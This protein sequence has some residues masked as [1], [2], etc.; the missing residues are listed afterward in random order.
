VTTTATHVPTLEELGHLAHARELAMNGRGRV[1]PNPL[2]GAIVVNGGRV[3]G[4]GWHEGPGTPHAEVGALRDAGGGA[5]DAT[6]VCTLEPCSHHGRTPPCTDAII[7]SGVARV[8]IGCLDP[9]ERGR[10]GGATVLAEAGVD[11][12]LAPEADAEACREQNAAFVTHALTGRPLVT[13]KLATS[14]D[15]KVATATGETRWI[16][17]PESRGLV[18]RWRADMDAVA[19][20]IGTALADDPLLNVRD[21]DG[22]YRPPAR[23]VFD[24]HARLPLR[25]RLVAGA[26]EGP[27]IVVA[28]ADAP[29]DRVGRL[30]DA[31]VDVLQPALPGGADPVG[32]ALETLGGRGIQSLLLEGGPIL[33][34]AFLAR[35]AVDRV[36]WFVAPLLIGGARAPGALGGRGLGPLAE[37]PRLRCVGVERVGG[38]VLVTGHLRPLAGSEDPG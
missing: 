33:A 18:H 14:L 16:S 20:G 3:V 6:L 13:L 31:G 37:V 1:S 26:G 19:V 22:A 32:A 34:E 5:R 24:R 25:S 8:V 36:A 4:T 38:D 11:V 23:I 9:L 35:D 2:V 10:A 28:A 30:R 12:A 29:A 15:G 27:V 17:G 7:A 21:V